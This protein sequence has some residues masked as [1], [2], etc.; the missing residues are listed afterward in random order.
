[1][2]GGGGEERQLKIGGVSEQSH[3]FWAG[4]SP[5]ALS[6]R[7]SAKIWLVAPS[8]ITTPRSRKLCFTVAAFNFVGTVFIIVLNTARVTNRRGQEFHHASGYLMG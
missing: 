7:L 3:K 1:M 2:G 4:A 8:A 5:W 6:N